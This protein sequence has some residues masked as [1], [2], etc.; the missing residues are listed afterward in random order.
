M[1]RHFVTTNH[2]QSACF[3]TS[4]D[5]LWMSF[6][7]CSLKCPLD[8][9]PIH[10]TAVRWANLFFCPQWAHAFV[11]TCITL[12]QEH[13]FRH[14]FI[15]CWYLSK[16]WNNY[17]LFYRSC[18]L[19]GVCC[20]II[21]KLSDLNLVQTISKFLQRKRNWVITTTCGFHLCYQHVLLFIL[22]TSHVCSLSHSCS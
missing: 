7:N 13:T 14:H 1:F 6:R 11:F 19:S 9:S 21:K 8:L 2:D 5:E 18:L 16:D 22:I 15:T 10:W 12:I 3:A 17:Y 4:K 20:L